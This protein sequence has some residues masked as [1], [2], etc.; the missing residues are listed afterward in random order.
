MDINRINPILSKQSQLIK[1]NNSK[2]L[3]NSFGNILKNTMGE[4]ENNLDS[5]NSILNNIVTGKSDDFYKFIIETE[6]TSMTLELTLQVRN[7]LIDSYK[8]IMRMQL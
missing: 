2:S 1:T 7:K 3:N 5:D 4:L 8:E 6:K